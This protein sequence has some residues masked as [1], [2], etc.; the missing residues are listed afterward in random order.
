MI[1]AAGFIDGEGCIGLSRQKQ[2]ASAV[3]YYYKVTLQVGQKARKPLDFLSDLFG[4]T[5][6]QNPSGYYYWML[7]S[8]KAV[9][10]LVEI[11]PFLVFKNSQ[12]KIVIE[13]QGRRGVLPIGVKLSKSQL[14]ADDR[15]FLKMRTL[16]DRTPPERLHY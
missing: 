4:G 14:K 10:A 16:N 12:A 15:D 9:A 8:R 2:P 5:V 13:F 7:S 6:R 11:E 1:W 3:G